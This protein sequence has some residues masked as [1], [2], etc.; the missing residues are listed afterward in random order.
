MGNVPF[1]EKNITN[2]FAAPRSVA[3]ADVDG[4]GDID[5]LGAAILDDKITWW[6]NTSGDGS[7]WT[8]ND[9]TNSFDAAYDV[10][11]ADVDGD[12]DIDIL[13]AAYNDDKITWWENTSSDGSNWTQNDITASFNGAESV[14]SADVDGDGD[15]D[16]L[17]AA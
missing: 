15:I 1:S 8:Q 6:E 7:T 5:I 13:G 17:G 9:I 12:G 11:S 16:I 3:S 4:D 2:S 14:A 10:A